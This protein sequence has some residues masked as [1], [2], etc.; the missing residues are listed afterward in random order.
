VVYFKVLYVFL[1]EMLQKGTRTCQD[2]IYIRNGDLRH[3][4]LES[5]RCAN[6]LD[7]RRRTTFLQILVAG[8]HD[9]PK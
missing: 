5:Y 7:G 4:N 1:F 6:L 2:I 3:R 9:L 8:P